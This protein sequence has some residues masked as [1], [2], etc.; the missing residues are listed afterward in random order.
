MLLYFVFCCSPVDAVSV[1]VEYV[2]KGTL[3][4]HC[5]D[6]LVLSQVV[7]VQPPQNVIRHDFEGAEVSLRVGAQPACDLP[8]HLSQQQIRLV[9]L[10]T[11]V[12]ACYALH[13]SQVCC[14]FHQAIKHLLVINQ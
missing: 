11:D 14:M 9:C 12:V 7:L 8:N 3:L 2:S 4:H 1:H 5:A 6:V 10:P 13:L